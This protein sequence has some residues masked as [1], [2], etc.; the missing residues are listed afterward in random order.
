MMSDTAVVTND[1]PMGPFL[2][3]WIGQVFSLLGSELVQFALIWYLT[4][5]TGSAT[6]LA[7]ASIFQMT[8]SVFIGPFAGVFIDRWNRRW[9]MIISDAVVALSTAAL[10]ILFWMGYES[11]VL[12]PAIFAA[13]LV[14]ATGSTFHRP[15]MSAT[16]ALMVPDRHLTRVAGLNQ[17]LNGGL[18][19]FAMPL[20]AALME[21]L[22]IHAI[23]AIDL[24]TATIAI[25]PLLFI[26]IPQPV[27]SAAAAAGVRGVLTELRE[28]FDYT[29]R[30]TG[31]MVI[32]AMAALINF[33]A[34]P[35]F[36]L[37]PLLVKEYFGKGAAE[38]ANTNFVF[39]VGVIAGG[40]LLGIWGGFKKRIYTAALGLVLMGACMGAIGL[41]SPAGFVGLLVAMGLL[42][43]VQSLVNGSFGAILQATIAPQVFG[44]V[45]SLT[46]S[47]ATGLSLLGLAI[48]GPVADA[49][50]LSPIYVTGGAVT[51]VMGLAI[52][53]VRATREIE[54]E[55]KRHSDSDNAA[56]ELVPGLSMTEAASL[57]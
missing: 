55:A 11:D 40:I 37:L 49:I 48:A 5:E 47:L 44:R 12:V 35:A 51:I 30:W 54:A 33:I 20:G 50:G 32:V 9:T 25:T 27:R 36:T 21:L 3:I 14:R 42:G 43:I 4:R 45:V 52:I 13:L 38:F 16:T 41:L 10:A 39:G 53:A 7:T 28:G 19:I 18:S 29:W 46:S 57:D 23:I 34:N 6:I 24:V 17:M 8:P 1:K 56:A 26:A 2:T 15:S 31:L 22:P